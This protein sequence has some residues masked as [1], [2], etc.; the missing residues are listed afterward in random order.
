MQVK[1]NRN[2]KG[3]TNGVR[4]IEFQ[5]NETYDIPE[6]L[7]QTFIKIQAAEP[8]VHKAQSFETPEK[9]KRGRPKKWL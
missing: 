8:I 4:I 1:I 3:S 9:R 6:E 2:I 5:V 7:A